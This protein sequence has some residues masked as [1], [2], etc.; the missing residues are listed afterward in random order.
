MS[1]D[2]FD[3]IMNL[4]GLRICRPFYEKHKQMLLYV[5]F[6]GCATVVSIGSFV[7]LDTALGIDTLVANVLS[8]I[9]TVG[10][11]YVTNRTWVFHSSARG[12]GIW[13]ELLSFYAARVLTLGIEE[14]LLLVFVTWLEQNSTAIKVI[15]QIVVLVG[16]YG[17]SK[18]LIF[19]KQ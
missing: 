5:F 4:P 1:R 13:K 14:G 9:L 19:R 12:K 15:A 17:I 3:R 18:L 8:W 7:L 16:N 11:A 6:G 10:F 2:V